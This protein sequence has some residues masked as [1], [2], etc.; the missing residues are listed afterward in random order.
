MLIGYAA[1]SLHT[2]IVEVQAAVCGA[3]TGQVVAVDVL[4]G[5]IDDQEQP[6]DLVAAL[7]ED[8]LPHVAVD[9]TLTTPMWLQQQQVWGGRLGSQGCKDTHR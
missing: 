2:V 6:E 5:P 9:D 7:C 8:V 3:V 1:Q 4:V